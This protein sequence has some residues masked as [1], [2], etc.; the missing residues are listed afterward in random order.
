MWPYIPDDVSCTSKDTLS[1][2]QAKVAYPD[3]ANEDT[4]TWWSTQMKEFK[5]NL[6]DFDGIWIDMN[7]PAHIRSFDWDYDYKNECNDQNSYN[8]PPYLARVANDNRNL[9][10]S[11]NILE[12]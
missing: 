12:S 7:E 9:G 1:Q 3:F 11:R 8:N 5:D 6:V 4:K 2:C 10:Q